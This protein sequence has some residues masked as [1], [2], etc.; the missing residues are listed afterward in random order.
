MDPD[1]PPFWDGW[2][3]RDVRKEDDQV[4]VWSKYSGEIAYRLEQAYLEREAVVELEEIVVLLVNMTEVNKKDKTTRAIR[5]TDTRIGGLF[6]GR[7][8]KQ[9]AQKQQD[10]QADPIEQIKAEEEVDKEHKTTRSVRQLFIGRQQQQPPQPRF[11]AVPP[12]K[13]PFRGN[14]ARRRPAHAT[15]NMGDD[16]RGEDSEQD[17]RSW[18][19]W[20]SGN[21][22]KEKNELPR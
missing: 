14:L 20:F 8:Q 6:W 7:L 1:N 11:E 18:F 16:M 5:R 10:I 9:R 22:K 13:T 4:A 17:R 3:E 12:E 21:K 19:D 2:W 15:L